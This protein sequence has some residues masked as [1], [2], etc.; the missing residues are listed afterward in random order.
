VPAVRLDE[1]PDDGEAEAEAAL[2]DA[3]RVTRVAVEDARQGVRP[4]SSAEYPLTCSKFW[5]QRRNRPSALM[6]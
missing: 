6:G 4:I 5:F 3:R 1:V 2:T